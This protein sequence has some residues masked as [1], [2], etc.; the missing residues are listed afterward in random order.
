M[1]K[2]S[3]IAAGITAAAVLAGLLWWQ[4]GRPTLVGTSPR[5]V[6][7]TE[8]QL[9][10]VVPTRRQTDAGLWLRDAEATLRRLEARMSTWIDSSEV[11]RLNAAPAGEVTDLSPDTLDVLRAARDAY[12]QTGGAFDVTCRPLV[13]LWRRAGE[14]GQMPS[15][16]EIA[17]AR[18][19]SNWD[20]L[21]ITPD[22]T[23]VKH[24]D[25]CCVDLGGIAKGY[26]IDL[27]A[28]VPRTTG[29][30]GRTGRR[31]RRRASLRRRHPGQAVDRRGEKP[32]R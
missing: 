1:K 22:G 9:A 3:P 26:A 2:L 12:D 18:E 14:S 30:L 8:C 11:S 23:V 32:V 15:D 19:A 29:G 7:G 24:R 4:S 27:A 20:L 21:K 25:S 5:A 31:R 13:Q 17:A 6:M 16:A 28:T 10:V